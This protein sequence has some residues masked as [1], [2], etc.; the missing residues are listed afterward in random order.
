MRTRENAQN[1]GARRERTAT[2]MLLLARLQQ[3]RVFIVTVLIE[4]VIATFCPNRKFF[5]SKADDVGDKTV[6]DILFTNNLL[7]FLLLLVV[8]PPPQTHRE[9]TATS[10]ELKWPLCNVLVVEGFKG[11]TR[12]S[13]RGS[14]SMNNKMKI[15]VE[16]LHWFIRTR[17]ITSFPLPTFTVH[18]IDYNLQQPCRSI[19]IIYET[20]A[21]RKKFLE[22]LPFAPDR[23]GAGTSGIPWRWTH[24]THSLEVF[25]FQKLQSSTTTTTSQ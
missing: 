20:N 14:Q 19:A 12:F 18:F 1:G 2:T 8:E 25:F 3:H 7:Y 15:C 5:K 6:G 4:N 16:Y 10:R 17:H 11:P 24:F 9:D 13:A 23:E 22:Q 21:D